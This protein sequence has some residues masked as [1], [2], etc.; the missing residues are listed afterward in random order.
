MPV[1]STREPSPAFSRYMITVFSSLALKMFC[2]YCN[3][4]KWRIALLRVKPYQRP[5][6][7]VSETTFKSYDAL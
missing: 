1:N 5:Y 6:E 4:A 2:Y 3:I 7:G